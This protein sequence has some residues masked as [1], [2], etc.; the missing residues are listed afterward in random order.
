M[1]KEII[2]HGKNE[3]EVKKM[4]L[5]EFMRYVPSGARR[6][7]KRGFTEFQKILLKEMKK[8]SPNLKTHC[9]DMVIIPEM[10]GRI[11]KVYSGKEFKPVEI[12]L[13]MLGH[14]LGEFSHTRKTVSHS[15]AGIGATRSSKAVSA[16]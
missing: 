12:T 4:D 13:E 15:A 10:L 16:R 9:R 6:S 1:A 2:W 11:F 3:T 8:N 14:R 5:K 7:L